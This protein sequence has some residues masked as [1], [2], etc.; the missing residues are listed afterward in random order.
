MSYIGSD[1]QRKEDRRLLTGLGPFVGD[2]HRPG[3]LHA[4]IVRS[5]HAHAKLGAVDASDALAIDGVEA[6]I[7]WSD[8]ASLA[9]PIPGRVEPSPTANAALQYPLAGERVRY[10]GEPVAVVVA[11]TPYLAEDGADEVRID[12]EPLEPVLDAVRGSDPDATRLFDEIVANTAAEISSTPRQEIPWDDAAVTVHERLSLNRHFASCME[13]RGLLAEHDEA[14]GILKV[15][16]PTKVTHWNRRVLA[17]ML[18]L[19]EARIHFIEPEVGGAFGLR[20][21]FYPEDFLIPFCALRLGQ[22]VKWIEDRPE[23]FLAGA[24]SREQVYEVDMAADREGRILGARLTM[25]QDLGAYVRTNGLVP[26]NIGSALFAG[27]Y[28]FP[29]ERQVVCVL[30]NKTPA[31]T[32]RAPGRFESSLVREQLI[33]RIA[34]ELGMDPA[35]IRMKNLIGADELPYNTGLS[36][37]GHA[38]VY[39]S[40]DYGAILGTALEKADY[41]RRNEGGSSAGGSASRE[42]FGTGIGCFIEKGGAGTHEYCR[43]EMKADGRLVLF[44][45][46]ASVGQ[47][48]ETVLAQIAADT[49]GLDYDHVSVRHG[50]TDEVPWGEGAW[51]SRATVH[52]GNCTKEVTEKLR[53]ELVARAADELEVAVEDIGIVDGCARVKA[54]GDGRAVALADLAGKEPDGIKIEHEYRQEHM[55]YSMGATIVKVAVDPETGEIRMI[56][57]HV[58]VDTGRAINEALIDGQ[59][60]GGFCQGIGGTLMELLAYG[61]DGQLLTTSFMDYLIPTAEQMP[62]VHVT[63]MDYPSPMNPLGVKGAGEGGVSATGGAITN[64]V[65]DALRS[66]GIDCPVLGPPLSPDR[67]RHIIRSARS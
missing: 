45:G 64:A 33:D 6:V 35:E 48:L 50:D 27:P 56:E 34:F 2:F 60:V 41:S 22:P 51:A 9:K 58:V 7:T 42:L 36:A 29:F 4:A 31:G 39:D 65:A 19:P 24:H 15:W 13:T 23:H 66:N 62:P 20:G 26:A 3:T 53:D 61:P 46:G 67:V 52:S 18:E 54:A 55:T 57:G 47:G 25:Y 38:V 28:T 5:G 17:E 21:E 30:T 8:I 37:L 16:G 12:Y 1:T 63:T 14:T 49:L 40:G 32:Y 10:V 59:V 43:A 11:A 44:S